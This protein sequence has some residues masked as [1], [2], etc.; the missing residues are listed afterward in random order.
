MK[1]NMRICKEKLKMTRIQ[2]KKNYRFKKPIVHQI[3]ND[4]CKCELCR[5][6]KNYD[7]KKKNHTDC[8]EKEVV[9][10]EGY[11]IGYI[12]TYGKLFEKFHA[13]RWYDTSN[14][15]ERRFMMM[16]RFIKENGWIYYVSS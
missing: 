1:N 8:T 3:P 5:K 13:Y 15:E 6:F 10:E 4:N 14:L 2:K 7:H 12:K 11:G 16:E 9:I